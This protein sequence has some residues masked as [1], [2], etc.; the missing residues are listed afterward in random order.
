MN[1]YRIEQLVTVRELKRENRD[2]GMKTEFREGD[3]LLRAGASV[4]E[5]FA[6]IDAEKAHQYPIVKMCA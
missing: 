1:V 4:R 2:L 6:C 3:C 5:K